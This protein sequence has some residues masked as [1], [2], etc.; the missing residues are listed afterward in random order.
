[1]E[2]MGIEEETKDKTVE[3]E[4][5]AWMTPKNQNKTTTRNAVTDK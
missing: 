3:R 5:V 2:A 4:H 1:M